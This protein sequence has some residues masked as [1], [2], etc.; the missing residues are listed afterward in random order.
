MLYTR[1][2]Q[3]DRNKTEYVYKKINI[4]TKQEWSQL[5]LTQMSLQMTKSKFDCIDKV[6]NE[7]LNVSKDI[8]PI[9]HLSNLVYKKLL[10]E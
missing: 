3:Y 9:M 6:K 7:T 4:Q 8:Y 10:Y 2:L 5:D 1:T